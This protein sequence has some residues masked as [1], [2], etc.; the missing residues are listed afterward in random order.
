MRVSAPQDISAPLCAWSL[1][2]RYVSA[3]VKPLDL[4]QFLPQWE[5]SPEQYFGF[6]YNSKCKPWTV[7]QSQAKESIFLLHS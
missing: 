2:M 1:A 3:D 4:D 7:V 5:E 6:H